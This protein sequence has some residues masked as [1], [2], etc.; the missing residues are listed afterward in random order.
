VETGGVGG[1]GGLRAPARFL[2]NG[3]P[4]SEARKMI[5][6]PADEVIMETPGG[7][8]YGAAATAE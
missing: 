1:G 4:V 6:Q 8:G 5:M 7:G 2:V 3:K